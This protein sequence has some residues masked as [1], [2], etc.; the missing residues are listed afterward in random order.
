MAPVVYHCFNFMSVDV[1]STS[2]IHEALVPTSLE[3]RW[4][5][6][7]RGKRKNSGPVAAASFCMTPQVSGMVSSNSPAPKIRM[8]LLQVTSPGFAL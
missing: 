2:S 1:E 3:P 8:C 7:Q 6:R 5:D 4:R